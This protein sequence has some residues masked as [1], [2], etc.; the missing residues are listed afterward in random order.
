MKKLLYYFIPLVVLILACQPSKE[1]VMTDEEA[2]S[3]LNRFMET[4]TNADTTYIEEIMHPNCVLT[5]PVLPEPI[6]GIDECKKFI[7]NT[8]N[9]FSEFIVTVEL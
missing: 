4:I 7:L 5:Y 8:A 3:L 2:T 6:K 9:T 1:Q